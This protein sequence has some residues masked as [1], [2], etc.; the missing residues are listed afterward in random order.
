MDNDMQTKCNFL[1]GCLF[2]TEKLG[3]FP[4][5]GDALRVTLCHKD[6]QNCARHII[7]TKLGTDAVPYN[8]LPSDHICA[9]RIIE[10]AESS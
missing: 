1:Q 10:E 2:I 3:A 6:Y 5:M 7:W 8:L 9:E 4:H